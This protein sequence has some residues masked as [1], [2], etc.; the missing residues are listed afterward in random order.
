M[1]AGLVL[2]HDPGQTDRGAVVLLTSVKKPMSHS[3]SQRH[4]HRHGSN[5]HF[6]HW[7]QHN[8][9]LDAE[10]THMVGCYY[11][12]HRPQDGQWFPADELPRAKTGHP[13]AYVAL[14][15]HGLY[16]TASPKLSCCKCPSSCV[17]FTKGH[18][19]RNMSLAWPVHHCNSCCRSRAVLLQLSVNLHINNN[20]W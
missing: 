17:S 4:S 18:H 19:E 12:A 15:A 6:D 8:C 2:T 14:G 7:L 10:A 13:I 11:H 5:F 3:Q 1:L 20:Q 9:R 16:N